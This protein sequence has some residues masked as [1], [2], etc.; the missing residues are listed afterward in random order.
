MSHYGRSDMIHQNTRTRHA[1]S[2]H[3]CPAARR[4]AARVSPRDDPEEKVPPAPVKWEGM[5]Q[6]VLEEWT[7]LVG[8]AEPLADHA[9]RV[10]APVE[11][12]VLSVLR[13]AA[14]KTL[15]EG[16]RVREGDVLARLDATVLLT[17]RDKAVSAKRVAQA[18]KETSEFAVKQA[19]LELRRLNELKRQQENRP[20][21]AVQLVPPIE[22]EKAEMALAAARARVRADE[23]KLVASDDEITSLDRQLKLYTLMAPRDGRLGR[24]QVVVGQTLAA[25][26]TVAEVIDVEDEI[27]VLCY[28][29]ASDVRKLRVGQP[30]RV[31]GVERDP[32]DGGAD[33]EGKIVFIADQAPTP[34]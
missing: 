19:E 18:E 1:D 26:A 28:V 17:T 13:D 12:R 20:A 30:V 11:G 8:T 6:L 23:V 27:D 24:F 31:G 22:V 16:Q 32:S 25:G 2:A 3:L 15:M 29:P 4:L 7:E 14:G 33:P 9:A 10:T 21:G 34:A 5:R